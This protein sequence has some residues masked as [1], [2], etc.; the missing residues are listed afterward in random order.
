MQVRD[1]SSSPAPL[2]PR[3][4]P[5]LPALTSRAD[6]PSLH[7]KGDDELVSLVDPGSDSGSDSGASEMMN[8]SLSS[9]PIHL[10]TSIET[11]YAPF[12]LHASAS[13]GHLLD[14]IETETA[15]ATGG[16]AGG[17]S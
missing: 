13:P 1:S 17:R 7:S 4:D 5:D 3:P 6:V 9:P 12:G 8:G 16:D 10:S 11:P 2:V 14:G 15:S